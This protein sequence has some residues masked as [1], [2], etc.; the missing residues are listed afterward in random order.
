ML[1]RTTLDV[2]VWEAV[3]VTGPSMPVKVTLLSLQ[4]ILPC[5]LLLQP[6]LLLLLLIPL[7]ALL[8][9]LK[10]LGLMPDLLLEAIVV[11]TL[12]VLELLLSQQLSL[13]ARFRLCRRL[14]PS[15][16]EGRRGIL[17]P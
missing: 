13:F 4:L 9:L 8:L 10:V 15:A 16:A 17:G 1:S 7:H 12:L 5:P 6:E 2:P 3:I 14:L 11:Q